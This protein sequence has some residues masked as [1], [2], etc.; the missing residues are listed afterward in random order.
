[1]ADL[2]TLSSK[3]STVAATI[4]NPVILLLLGYVSNI[5]LLIEKQASGTNPTIKKAFRIT[6]FAV[7]EFEPELRA[8]V[9]ASPTDFDDKLIDELLEAADEILEEDSTG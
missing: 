2:K 5:L 3:F 4:T 7:N 8:A 9:V 1:M 6:M